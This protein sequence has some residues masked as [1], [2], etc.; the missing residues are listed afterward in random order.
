[1][2]N[3][4]EHT[5]TDELLARYLAGE[6]DSNETQQVENWISVSE[7]N[8]AY[9][10]SMK[11]TWSVTASENETIFDTDAAWSRMKVRMNSSEEISIKAPRNFSRIAASITLFLIVT[12]ALVWY[13]Q[14]NPVTVQPLAMTSTNELVQDTLPDGSI[15]SLNKN[16][17]LTYPSAFTGEVREVTLSGEAFFEVH[18]DAAHPFIIHT[19]QLDIKVLGTSFNVSAYPKKDFVRVSVKTGKVQCFASND[20]VVLLPG[21]MVL[22]DERAGKMNKAPEDDPNTLAYRNHI[23]RFH[24]IKLSDAIRSL[25]EVYG[26]NIRLKNDKLGDCRFTIQRDVVDQPLDSIITAISISLNLTFE[27]ANNMI[28]FDGKPCP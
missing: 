7:E 9:F 22:Y 21:E 17:R 3:E 27:K 20:T 2:N 4:Q 28:L 24:D 8:R 15:I 10:E 5:P 6:T 11:K 13:L 19:G 12:V 26:S 16:S 14:P 23:F 25:N 18:K 1:M